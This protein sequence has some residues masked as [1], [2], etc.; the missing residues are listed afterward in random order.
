M[1]N[2][3][4]S[5]GLNYHENIVFMWGKWSSSGESEVLW[6]MLKISCLLSCSKCTMRRLCTAFLH[7]VMFC[8]SSTRPEVASIQPLDEDSSRGCSGRA[9]LQALSTQLSRLTSII[10]AEDVGRYTALCA[11]THTGDLCFLSFT[12]IYAYPWIEHKNIFIVNWCQKEGPVS[13]T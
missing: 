8:R 1:P 6:R 5:G 4:G 7:L 10:L 11:F 2:S 13:V 12:E 9:V 3:T